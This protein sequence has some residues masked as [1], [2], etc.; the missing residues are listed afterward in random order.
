MRKITP[1]VLIGIL[2]ISGFGAGAIST[3]L[4]HP[5]QCS[6]LDEYDMAIIAPDQFSDEIQ[7]L[8]NHKESYGIT[9]I[10]ETVETIYD[11]YQGRD[12][13]EKIKYFIK[14][15]LE[16]WTV[17]YVLLIG[18]RKGL[19]YEWYVPVR[20]VHL[21]DNVFRYPMYLTDLYFADIYD[22][23]GQFSDWD[24]NNNDVF[25]EF[26]FSNKDNLDLV[27][28]VSLG[29]LPCRNSREVQIIVDKIIDYE[30]QTYG[31]TWFTRMVTA[32]GDSNPGVGEPFPYE[33]EEICEAVTQIMNDFEITKLYL[34]DGSL[35]G[36]DD[37]LNAVNQGCGFLLL[38]GHGSPYMWGNHPPDDVE[39]II[40]G[41]QNWNIPRFQNRDMYPICFITACDT[42]KF[43][44][45]PF[46]IFRVRETN[47]VDCVPECLSWRMVRKQD[48]GTIANIASTS[49][50]WGYVGDA[51]NNDIFD[52]VEKGLS[53]WFILE[54]YRLY[55]E[56]N[57]DILGDLHRLALIN[58]LD[59]FPGMKYKLDCKTVQE[60]VLIGDPSLK[61]GGYLT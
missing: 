27:P 11:E 2:V 25:G 6:G 1:I 31:Q 12:E 42:A 5:Q 55:V 20:Y 19:S 53:G 45:T 7:P 49:T 44:V 14:D 29:R 13:A 22:S 41:L 48:G 40:Y 23:D 59:S 43:D 34:S 21:D 37:L 46:N 54:L 32:G 26:S 30:T 35:T 56:E 18:G 36:P 3:R 50:P 47:K 39:T 28:D 15:A 58:Y 57:I 60:Y 10:L 38:Q 8:I 52:G 17:K 16:T 51:N 4:P 61:I 33:G 24:T 9:T